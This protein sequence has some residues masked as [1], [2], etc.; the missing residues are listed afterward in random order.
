MLTWAKGCSK[1]GAVWAFYTWHTEHA[2]SHACKYT[3][4]HPFHS[5]SWLK[6]TLTRIQFNSIKT[7]EC[8]LPW[9]FKA[10][11]GWYS[12]ITV[13]WIQRI[14]KKL[15]C[16]MTRL[17]RKLVQGSSRY[18]PF[19]KAFL[20]GWMAPKLLKPQSESLSRTLTAEKWGNVREGNVWDHREMLSRIEEWTFVD[21]VNNIPPSPPLSLS[22]RYCNN[23]E[24][25]CPTPPSPTLLASFEISDIQPNHIICPMQ[26]IWKLQK[27]YR[28]SPAW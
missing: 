14:A 12:N 26:W 6:G 24:S 1:N 15:L 19:K 17:T 18:I 16:K 2:L 8:D 4:F 10:T 5:F 21:F 25:D 28:P 22:R 7:L 13:F 27:L 20:Q 23:M 9:S 11:N 3:F